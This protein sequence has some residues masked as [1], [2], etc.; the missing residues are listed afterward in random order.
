M[1]TFYFRL[2]ELVVLKDTDNADNQATIKD[3][4]RNLIDV[5]HKK[6]IGKVNA[7]LISKEKKSTVVI[8]EATLELDK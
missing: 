3:H 1:Y 2:Q 8:S 6:R 7:F 4:L 5:Y